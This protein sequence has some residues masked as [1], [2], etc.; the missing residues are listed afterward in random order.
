M[1][2][3]TPVTLPG[4][5]GEAA[6]RS[7]PEGV[8]AAEEGGRRGAASGEVLGEAPPGLQGRCVVSVGDIV[9]A[10]NSWAP[11]GEASPCSPVGGCW[12]TSSAAASPP[13]AEGSTDGAATDAVATSDTAKGR[14]TLGEPSHLSEAECPFASIFQLRKSARISGKYL[15]SARANI[16]TC[17]TAA[18]CWT[19]G[20][21]PYRVM[22]ELE[23]CP[24][25]S[26]STHRRAL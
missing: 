12:S 10:A 22:V 5:L 18:A 6:L 1:G 13:S 9:P 11:S 21:Y 4:W 7:R 14:I 20:A 3:L 8:C 25:R 17:A 15:I 24:T 16:G 23:T 2:T 19:K 26:F